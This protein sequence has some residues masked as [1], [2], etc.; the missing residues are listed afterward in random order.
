MNFSKSIVL[1]VGNALAIRSVATN[2]ILCIEGVAP[3]SQTF[4]KWY[5]SGECGGASVIMW[6][7][8]ASYVFTYITPVI[9]ICGCAALVG[10][11][12]FTRH[13]DGLP[14]VGRR[15]IDAVVAGLHKYVAYARL[16]FRIEIWIDVVDRELLP[17]K[18]WRS[19]RDGLGWPGSSFGISLFGNRPL[20]N[21]PHRLSGHAIKYI[22]EAK[23]RCQGN[24]IDLLPV[25]QHSQKLRGCRRIIIPEIMVHDLEVPYTLPCA[26]IER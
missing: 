3:L 20:F 9:R 15:S 16:L 4:L 23:L 12:I 18:W 6:I 5:S 1:G 11:S 24:D 21:W 2:A 22:E 26:S 8:G 14:I 13:F 25:V 17:R 7:V 19:C 10:A